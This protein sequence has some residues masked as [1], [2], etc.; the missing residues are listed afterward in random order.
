MIRSLYRTSDGH[1][2]A[3]LDPEGYR[4]ALQDPEGLLWIDFE[5]EP[6][7]VCEPI[8]RDIFKFHPL[9]VDDA[10]AESHVPK[11]DDWGGYVYVVLHAVIFDTDKED[12]KHLDTMEVDIFLGKNY[13]VTHHDYSIA[14]IGRVWGSCHRDERHLQKGADY[15]AYRLAD[16]LVADYMPTVEQMEE[17]IDGIEDEIFD[18]PAPGI[19]ERVFKLKRVLLRLRRIMMP[20]REVLNKLARGDFPQIDAESRAFFRDV[21][22]HLVRLNDIVESMRD[23]ISGVMETYLS[24]INNRMNEVMKTLT[25]ITTFFMPIAFI[26]AFFGMNFFLPRPEETAWINMPVLILA[27]AL[28]LLAPAGMYLWIRRR[29]WL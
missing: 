16:E 10:L 23:L 28:M 4:A 8:L 14:A 1:C 20:Q 22:D 18:R 15:L 3:N 26:A 5:G 24:V 11:V 25:L 17:V 21:Y 9:A 29:G 12:D 19:L 6:D 7:Q 2:S 27:L 13:V